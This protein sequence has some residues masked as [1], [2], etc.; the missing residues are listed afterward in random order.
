MA[1]GGRSARSR[2]LQSGSQ[3]A[4]VGREYI[5][6]REQNGE[7]SMRGT[8]PEW[9]SASGLLLVL[10]R[11]G[12]YL[13]FVN[14]FS[15]GISQ[16]V[17][18]GKLLICLLPNS[19]LASVAVLTSLVHFCITVFGRHNQAL[20]AVPGDLPPPLPP[21]SCKRPRPQL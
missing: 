10:N 6:G 7:C 18:G 19:V 2:P 16:Q 15:R 3:E 5:T 14:N 17:L 21:T 1:V 8:I 20:I 11:G 13:I 12:K 4:V 9:L